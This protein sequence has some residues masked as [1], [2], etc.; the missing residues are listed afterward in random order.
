MSARITVR[1]RLPRQLHCDLCLREDC[2]LLTFR[3]RL[4]KCGIVLCPHHVRVLLRRLG[5]GVLL[6]PLRRVG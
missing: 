2:V 4:G 3:L 5:V 6:P 1:K